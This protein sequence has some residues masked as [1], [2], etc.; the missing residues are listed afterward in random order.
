MSKENLTPDIVE[1]IKLLKEDWFSIRKIKDKVNNDMWTTLNFHHVRW[2]INAL[3]DEVESI[4]DNLKDLS[5]SVE[6]DQPYEVTEDHYIFHQKRKNAESWEIE[7][8]KFPIL[9]S[10]VDA[11][12]KDYSKHWNNLSWEEIL[13]KYNIKIELFNI[14][15]NRLRLFKASHVVSPVTLDR[16]NE[17]ELQWHIDWA[18]DEHIEDRYRRKFTSTFEKKRN[19]DYIVKSKKIANIDYELNVIRQFLEQYQPRELNIIREVITNNDEI[20]VLF[21]DLHIGKMWTDKV[22]S[23]IERMTTDIINRPEKKVNLICLWDLFETMAKWWMHPGQV[24]SMEWLYWFD[25]FKKV[26]DVFET[27]LASLYS[28]GKDIKFYWIGGNH[29][30][31]TANKE[32]WFAWIAALMVYEVIRKSLQNINIEIN[33]LRE[34]WNVLDLQWFRYILHHWDDWANKKKPSQILWEKWDREKPNIIA[35]WDKHH[36]EAI[37]PNTNATFALVPWMAWENEYD[38]K[39]LLASYPWYMIVAKDYFDQTPSTTIRRFNT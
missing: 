15:K 3:Q 34:T 12:F 21:S 33:L 26:I 39:L 6:E 9:I 4:K 38:K 29:D 10:T 36:H 14:I 22:L 7:I 5:D 16:C 18:I 8:N 31:F 23:R 19:E 30:R 2:I 13:Q 32:D 27:M 17:D 11:I 24:E 20:T 28:A 1:R 35:M 25:L 37:D